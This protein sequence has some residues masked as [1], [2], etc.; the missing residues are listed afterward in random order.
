MPPATTF[1][2]STAQG[3]GAGACI[4]SGP[5]PFVR[6]LRSWDM[7]LLL[8][9]TAAQALRLVDASGR[10]LWSPAA[11][12]VTGTGPLG[13]LLRTGAG[14]WSNSSAAAPTLQPPTLALLPPLAN[15][16]SSAAPPPPQRSPPLVADASRWQVAQAGVASGGST[17][18]CLRA[19]GSMLF[20]NDNDGA[21]LWLQP[22]P[23]ASQ[24]EL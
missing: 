19:D 5:V 1:Q 21:A 17:R 22:A 15:G 16:G 7:R 23:G 6:A 20:S 3:A 2:L 8:E 24:G 10:V 14:G 18:F 9:A 13:Q 4:H 12:K 11:A